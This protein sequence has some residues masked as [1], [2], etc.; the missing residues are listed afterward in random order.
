VAIQ[1]NCVHVHAGYGR[2]HAV[3]MERMRNKQRWNLRILQNITLLA[4]SSRRSRKVYC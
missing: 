4:L 3:F 1:R 2:V